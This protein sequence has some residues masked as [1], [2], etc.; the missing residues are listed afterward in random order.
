MKALFLLLFC[1]VML[2][3]AA[4]DSTLMREVDAKIASHKSRSDSISTLIRDGKKQILTLSKKE[5]EQLAMLNEMEFNIEISHLY[6]TEL[7]KET[8]SLHQEIE[9][10]LPQIDSLTTAQT[11]RISLM[12]QRVRQL[13]KMGEP[14]ILAIILGSHSPDEMKHRL[15][16]AQY[17]NRYDKSLLREIQKSQQIIEFEKLGLEKQ[18][19]YL[20]IIKEDKQEEADRITLQISERKKHLHSIQEE[21]EKWQSAIKELRVAQRELTHLVDN[22]VEKKRSIKDDAQNRKRLAF[23][24]KKGILP[25]PVVGR[26]ITSFGKVV[27]P[28]YKTTTVS[29]GIDIAV[30]KGKKVAAV[31]AGVVEFVGQMRGYGKLV[32]I[33]HKGGY[34]TIYAHL[35]KISVTKGEKLSSKKIIG[36]V[37]ESGSLEGTKLH[38]E[39]RSE[40][41]TVNPEEWLKPRS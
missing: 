10:L 3:Q 21:K 27:H 24:K 14:N 11:K 17:L 35:D 19:E 37:G 26:V 30:S 32:V 20:L 38:F 31:A 1:S 12:A 33:D 40:S 16:M 4:M 25:W 15:Q 36:Q 41:K 18:E 6:I 2:I 23:E 34:R 39:I 5:D 28:K 9:L 8:D 7:G 13:Y 22:L 29:N